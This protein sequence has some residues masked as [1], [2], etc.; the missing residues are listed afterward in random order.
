MDNKKQLICKYC[1]EQ[2]SISIYPG[3]NEH[4]LIVKCSNCKSSRNYT[5]NPSFPFIDKLDCTCR[6]IAK[7]AYESKDDPYIGKC[8]I[9]GCRHVIKLKPPKPKPLNSFK[10]KDDPGSFFGEE[11]KGNVC[12]FCGEYRKGSCQLTIENEINRGFQANHTICKECGRS[13]R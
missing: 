9:H 7:E 13:Y 10:L 11:L 12:S 1:Y 3:A 2:D 8:K 4:E 5:C 6:K